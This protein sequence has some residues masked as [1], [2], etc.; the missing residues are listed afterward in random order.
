MTYGA[1]V[2]GYFGLKNPITTGK[3]LSWLI[4]IGIILSGCARIIGLIG[5][6]V[7]FVINQMLIAV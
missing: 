2:L 3:T 1:V 4:G 5:I 6:S 7:E